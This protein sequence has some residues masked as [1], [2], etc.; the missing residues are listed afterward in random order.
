MLTFPYLTQTL[1]ESNRLTIATVTQAE[2]PEHLA[3]CVL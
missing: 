3:L 2:C 1:D